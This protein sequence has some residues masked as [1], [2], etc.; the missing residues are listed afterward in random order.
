KEIGQ[1]ASFE[2]KLG[3]SADTLADALEAYLGL[4]RNLEKVYVYSH[5]KNDQDT[6]N[7]YYQGLNDRAQSL[8]T[9]ASEAVSWF[10][11]E[12]LSLPEEKLTAYQNESDRLKQYEHFLERLTINREHVLSKEMEAL[13]AGAG[14]IFS[15]P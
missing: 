1:V 7:S 9:K 4:F 10:E 3:E 6:S 11:P 2:G 13:I 5:L 15:S 8:A 12:V 14:E